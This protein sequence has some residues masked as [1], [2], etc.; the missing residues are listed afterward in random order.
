MHPRLDLSGGLYSL[1]P[2]FKM[3]FDLE[4]LKIKENFLIVKNFKSKSV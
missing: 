1:P 2:F 3:L 4:T